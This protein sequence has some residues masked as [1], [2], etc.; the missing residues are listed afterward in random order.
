MVMNA[1][2]YK[3]VSINS[4]C[5]ELCSSNSR[6]KVSKFREDWRCELGLVKT[7]SPRFWVS[8]DGEGVF[9]CLHRADQGGRAG[10]GLV[11]ILYVPADLP[12]DKLVALYKEAASL[13]KRTKRESQ[14]EWDN[15]LKKYEDMR[16]KQSEFSYG[17]SSGEN[18]AYYVLSVNNAEEVLKKLDQEEYYNYENVFF[19]NEDLKSEPDGWVDLS[20][21]LENLHD[22]VYLYFVQNENGYKPYLN[23]ELLKNG[24]KEYYT[25]DKSLDIKWK[26]DCYKSI[27]RKVSLKICKETGDKISLELEPNDEKLLIER[28][29]FNGTWTKI[30]VGGKN[31]SWDKPVSVFSG[32][33]VTIK[34][35]DGKH[36]YEDCHVEFSQLAEGVKKGRI[37][38]SLREKKEN[39]THAEAWCDDLLKELEAS[40]I[41]ISLGKI[42]VEG[43]SL[44]KDEQRRILKEFFSSRRYECDNSIYRNTSTITESY[45]SDPLQCKK[46]KS[47]KNRGEDL[48]G[49]S[50]QRNLRSKKKKRIIILLF[51]LLALLGVGVGAYF[52]FWRNNGDGNQTE[53]V[54]ETVE[55]SANKSGFEAGLYDL[56]SKAEWKEVQGWFEKNRGRVAS[57]SLETQ[58]RELDSLCRYIVK[59]G[60][61]VDGSCWQGK[62]SEGNL[63]GALPSF[64]GKVAKSEEDLD[65][66]KELLAKD[67]W[68]RD[69]FEQNAY[70]KGLWDAVNGYDYD[71]LQKFKEKSYV[72]KNLKKNIGGLK[73]GN[74]EKLK[75]K[76]SEGK[77]NKPGDMVI[78][79]NLY[80]QDVLTGNSA[81]REEKE[82][83]NTES[84]ASTSLPTDN[85]PN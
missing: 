37:E 10:D 62:Y 4:G 48:Y 53:A 74:M 63:K 23:D 64:K 40:S 35:E 57:S 20:K 6:A 79:M 45:Y 59:R 24:H 31:L 12:G 81:G 15:L 76:N 52:L 5:S 82:N 43:C 16:Q 36:N 68:K 80:W 70:L 83:G 41:K 71:F 7:G 39:C 17:K 78:T 61:I 60:L 44:G 73:E 65:D 3:I 2:E 32:Q 34:L 14:N 77:R 22:V 46:G 26:K 75:K 29:Y 33:P 8:F 21:K 25:G 72:P 55:N 38:L 85:L 58:L 9:L 13:L 49:R 84:E 19:L 11:A 18:N 28:R 51:G 50:G 54:Q 56:C 69:D 67:E 30:L 27:D 1:I 47:R 66:A 42:C